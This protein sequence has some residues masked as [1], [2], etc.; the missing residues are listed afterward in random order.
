MQTLT[1]VVPG[2]EGVVAQR[3]PFVVNVKAGQR[4]RGR[5]SWRDLH[6][7]LHVENEPVSISRSAS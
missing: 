7:L 3:I 6:S 2:V 1:L 5:A 4:S